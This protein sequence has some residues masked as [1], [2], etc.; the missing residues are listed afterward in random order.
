MC[1]LIV[2]AGFDPEVPLFVAANRDE[3]YERKSSPPGLWVGK[4]NR[5]L[6]PRDVEAG[7]TWIGV[8]QHGRF[9]AVTNLAG[10]P[11]SRDAPTRGRLV[12]T[13]L[14]A[15][16]G[17]AAAVSAVA[18]EV[19]EGADN[20]FQL[21]VSDGR[22][23]CVLV[24]RAGAGR[25][26]RRFD[27]EEARHVVAISNEHGPGEL[28]LAPLLE[29]ALVGGLDREAR[30]DALEP[31]LRH[32]GGSGDQVPHR[33]LKVGDSVYGTVSGS[34]LAV[35]AGGLESLVWRYSAGA[36]GG[37]KWRNYGNLGHRLVDGG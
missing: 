11:V 10:E 5:V 25:Q 35:P 8:D 26:A 9:A 19:A 13:A 1:S 27:F 32:P 17:T 7:G 12:F 15:E 6:A 3:F 37:A 22:T 21:L 4:R 2:L 24:H 23:S 36:P 30:L 34:L 29:P 20:G 28:D 31:L 16:P 33:L 18:G 14:D